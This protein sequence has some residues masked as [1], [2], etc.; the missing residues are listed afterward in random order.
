MAITG[1]TWVLRMPRTPNNSQLRSLRGCYGVY[2]AL[3][4]RMLR[5][6]YN[7]QLRDLRAVMGFTWRFTVEG[8]HVHPIKAHPDVYVAVTVSMWRL[9]EGCHVHPI[10]A[11]SEVYVAVTGSMWGLAEG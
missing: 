7:S 5:T 10:K 9:V 1:S 8:C 3:S 4:G 6:P 2:V 11:N